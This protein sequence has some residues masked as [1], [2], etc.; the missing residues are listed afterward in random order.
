MVLTLIKFHFNFFAGE[1]L[2]E[3][4]DPYLRISGFFLLYRELNKK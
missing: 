1:A 3:G 2:P 4:I